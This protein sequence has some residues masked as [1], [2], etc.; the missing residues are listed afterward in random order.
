MNNIGEGADRVKLT[1]YDTGEWDEKSHYVSDILF[2][3]NTKEDIDDMDLCDF[4]KDKS[5]TLAP[6]PY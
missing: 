1:K 4:T 2:K 3:V 5:P 6:L